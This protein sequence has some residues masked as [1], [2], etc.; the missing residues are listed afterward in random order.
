MTPLKIRGI[1]F[2]L[3][4]TLVNLG[5][6][7]RWRDAQQ[8]II[9]AYR[10]YNCSEEDLSSCTTKGLFNLIHEMETRLTAKKSSEEI[11]TICNNIWRILDNYEI[12]GVEK[13]S[14]MP[15][16][17]E[18]L[19]WLN[20]Q[21]VIMAICTSNSYKVAISILMR[22]QISSYFK[23]VIGRTPNLLMKPYPDQPLSCFKQ[24]GVD[25][26]DGVMVGDSHNDVLAGRAAGAKTVAIPVYFTNKEA[27]EAAKPDAV[28]KSMWELP[29]VLLSF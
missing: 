28:I 1:V 5:E 18:T 29:T 7:V 27:M 19:D 11:E 20:D 24:M 17:R 13:C 23:S 9:K 4:A 15:G 3:D 10:S 21:R 8:E 22:L 26:R 6:H 16:T 25:P 2:D 12:E 14:L